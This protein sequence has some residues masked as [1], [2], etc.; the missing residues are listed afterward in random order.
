MAMIRVAPVQVHVRTDW[1]NGRPR[2]VTWGEH[3][4]PVTAVAAVREES[5]AY[6]VVVGPRTVFEVDTPLARLTLSFRHRTRRWS[7]EG[8]DEA[9]RPAA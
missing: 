1:F 8:L 5:S 2:E 6:P 4:L 3:R 9:V 7:I